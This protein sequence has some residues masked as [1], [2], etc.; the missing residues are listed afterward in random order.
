MSEAARSRLLDVANVSAW[1]LAR[2]AVSRSSSRTAR[3]ALRSQKPAS[4]SSA[5]NPALGS[6]ATS[7]ASCWISS[8]SFDADARR[9][10]KLRY[11]F[12]AVSACP[13]NERKFSYAATAT[14]S[15]TSSET[16]VR[17]Y[18]LGNHCVY[19]KGIIENSSSTPTT[20]AGTFKRTGRFSFAHR[21]VKTISY[22]LLR[23]QTLLSSSMTNN[24]IAINRLCNADPR[25][26]GTSIPLRIFPYRLSSGSDLFSSFTTARWM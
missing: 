9:T 7:T 1:I 22:S 18:G 13:G 12:S 10:R 3:P 17:T 4:N 25:S 8:S 14:G 20:I 5:R 24:P 11:R 19:Q 23:M 15:S 26:A 21:A 16:R 6:S 2:S